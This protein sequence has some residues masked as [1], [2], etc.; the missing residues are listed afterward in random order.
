MW[1]LDTK[2]GHF[3]S[4]ARDG[5]IHGYQRD[6]SSKMLANARSLVHP[7]D[8]PLLDAAFAASKRTGDRCKIEYRVGD[9]GRSEERW[10]ALDGAVVRGPNGQPD[11]LL[12]VTRD[13]TV[14]K[15][16]ERA[17]SDRNLQLT[18]AGKF[19]LVGTYAYDVGT[20]KYQIS[21]GYAAVHGLPEGTEETS[22]AEWRARV[23]A[24]DLPGVE[25][26]F[27]QAMAE[28]RRE[29]HCEYRL[30]RPDGEIRWID[31][32]NFISYDHAGSAPRLVGANI[33]VTQRKKTELV[34]D[35]RTVQLALAAK[36]ARV[37]SYAYDADS[38]V[39]SVSEGYAALHGLP[40]GTLV[41]TRS[42]WRA[43]TLPE[44][45]VR[46]ED[47][48][49]EAF[50]KRLNEYEIAYR[51]FRSGEIRWIESRSFISYNLDGSPRR[52]IGIN[53]D[54]TERKR[55]EDQQRVLVAELDHR[56]KN[57]LATVSAIINQTQQP[58]G[59]PTDFV[60]ALDSRI[61]SLAGTHE[62][63]SQSRWGGVALREIAQCEF[64]PYAADNVEFNG[65][66]VMLKAEAAQAMAMVLHELTTNAAKYGAF[67]GRGGRALLKWRW[68]D[69]GSHGRLAVEWREIG[70]PAVL[71]PR[72]S[73]YGTNIIREL[74]PFELGGTVELTFPG[75]G[76]RCW[77]EIPAEW[78]SR[79]SPL[80]TEPKVGLRA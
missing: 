33:D 27:H 51:I 49:Q 54:V 10:V 30:A 43:R 69:N 28:R 15:Q 24:D 59:S 4:D 8:L 55:A 6:S 63:L 13:I 7:D 75:D 1:S 50:R 34:L 14:H 35:E 11:Q 79:A 53:I 17:L 61:K 44:D 41:T 56:V 39:M 58:G 19:A 5:Q 80:D 2:T 40:E 71:T 22:R 42:E 68:L 9:A 57:V 47:V 70:G 31:S 23:H 64:A 77:M 36:A 67:S 45:R 76:V 65:P 62:L 38:D 25:A 32:R 73:S 66:D 29:Y 60:T 72:K 37:G 26:G 21:P 48:R 20:E 74:I 18:L 12:G 46:V 3:E 52:V 16:A 78:V